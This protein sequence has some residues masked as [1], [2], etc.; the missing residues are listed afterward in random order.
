MRGRRG[1]RPLVLSLGYA[2][3]DRVS[4]FAALDKPQN[5]TASASRADALRSLRR[6][7]PRARRKSAGGEVTGL[8][9]VAGKSEG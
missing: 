8:L 2:R 6:C 5:T 1:Q 4:R 7:A 9:R 3:Q